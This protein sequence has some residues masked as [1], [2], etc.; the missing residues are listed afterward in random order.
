MLNKFGLLVLGTAISS[1]LISCDSKQSDSKVKWE[2]SRQNT[3]DFA[4]LEARDLQDEFFFGMQVIGQE[5]FFASALGVQMDIAKVRLQKSGDRLS[6]VQG[7][8]RLLSFDLQ[9]VGQRYEV[10]FSSARNVLKFSNQDYLNQLGGAYTAGKNGQ[11]WKS[12]TAPVVKRVQQTDSEL[13]VDLE[14]TV[15]QELSKDNVS[16]KREGKVTIRLFLARV[17]AESLNEDIRVVEDGYDNNYGYFAPTYSA[18][19]SVAP[20]ARFNIAS[21][22]KIVFHIKDFPK[23]MESVAIDAILAWNDAFDGDV[24]EVKVADE[25]VDIADPRYNVVKW[26]ANTDKYISWAGVASPTF[27]DPETGTVI[28]GGAFISG[29][30]LVNKYKEH[31]DYT[32]AAYEQF[33]VTLGNANLKMV[34]GETPVV[35]YFTDGEKSFEEYMK[36]YYSETITHEV[37]HILGLMHNFKASVRPEAGHHSDSVMDYLPRTERSVYPIKV[38]RY[39]IDAIRWGYYGNPLTTASTRYDFCTHR[40]MSK[41][42]YCN[43]GDQGNIVDYTVNGLNGGVDLLANTSVKPISSNTINPY[44]ST[45]EN[46]LKILDMKSQLSDADLTKA[47]T[48]I[49]LAFNKLCYAKASDSLSAEAKAVA[50]ANLDA[51]RASVKKSLAKGRDSWVK[52]HKSLGLDCL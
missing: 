23:N 52:R 6:V 25:S 38:G 45:V 36:G 2:Q 34:K 3:Q 21:G 41:D 31:H 37:G 5:G 16:E 30:Y 24:V 27:K 33:K 44:A 9:R 11:I 19:E 20:I 13:I 50:N 1:S 15:E 29:D 22:N 35:P 28:S 46:A 12:N 7:N 47:L 49:P 43:M 48:E 51:L 18:D 26:V 17:G 39:D 10:D 8:T 14:H 42:V 32:E 40:H 4:F